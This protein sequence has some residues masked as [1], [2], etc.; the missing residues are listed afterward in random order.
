[1]Q[2][3]SRRQSRALVFRGDFATQDRRAFRESHGADAHLLSLPDGE[4][5]LPDAA[6]WIRPPRRASSSRSRRVCVNRFHVKMFVRR[7]RNDPVTTR[8][9]VVERELPVFA[10]PLAETTRI[11]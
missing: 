3:Q 8:L 10:H 5:V 1:M 11:L 6:R 7:T 4:T 9:D 2:S